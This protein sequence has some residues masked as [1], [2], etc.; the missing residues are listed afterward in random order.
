MKK[1]KRIMAVIMLFAMIMTMASGCGSEPTVQENTETENQE[2][3]KPDDEE[4]TDEPVAMGRY[5]EQVT[6]LSEQIGGYKNKIYKL[7]DGQIIISDEYQDFIVSK[8]NGATWETY[9]QD[10]FSKLLED[11]TYIHDIQVG[12]DGTVYVVVETENDSE[13]ENAEDALITEENYVSEVSNRLLIVKP[14]G[15]KQ[16]VETPVEGKWIYSVWVS[17]NGRVFITM[18]GEPIYEVKEDGSCEPFLTVD[19]IPALIQFQGNLMIIDG[20]DYDGYLIYDMEKKTYVEDEVLADFITENY[21]NRDTNGGSWHD[22][23][24]CTKEEGVLYLAGE[25]GLYRHVIGGSVMEQIVD[26]SLSTFGSPANNLEGFIPLDNNEFL[27]LFTGGKLIKYVYD[28]DIPTV[29]NEKLNIYSL[30][31]NDT[32]RQ[33]VSLYQAANPEVYVQYEVGIDE[34]SSVTKE[35]ALKSLNTRIMAGNGPDVLILDNM[36]M[37]AYVDK[38]LLMDL[39]PMLESLEEDSAVFANIVNAFEKNGKVYMMPCE[40]NLP[41]ILGREKTV[42]SMNDLKSMADGVEKMRDEISGADLIGIASER[43]IMKMFAMTCVPSWKTENGEINIQNISDFLEETKRIYDAQMNG[44]DSQIKEYW[45]N[46]NDYYMEDMGILRENSKYF[47]IG[48]DEIGFVGKSRQM[49]SGSIY[50]IFAYAMSTSVPRIK[51][52]E[53]SKL[54]L[55]PGQSQN[56]F[57]AQTIAGISAASKNTERGEEFLKV[58]LGKEN[59]VST[60][61]GLPVNKAALEEKL[62]P[63][64]KVG[65]NGEY[66]SIA[67]SDGEGNYVEMT[68][69]WPD[70]EI[71]NMLRGWIEN[72]STPY[73]EDVRLEDAVYKEG[74]LYMR[75]EK[76]LEEA[77]MAIEKSVALYMA[78]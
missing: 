74:A 66:S 31:Q 71:I 19:Q 25:K 3:N 55:M 33:A 20:Y 18:F 5:V 40:I 47:R 58:L 56:V 50:D 13:A 68:I 34:N 22:L 60:F 53:D 6:D 11:K 52:F 23:Y 70:E 63:S 15:T 8:D 76:S 36:P 64:E 29:P 30:K 35:D 2:E 17:E 46:L 14:D 37:D 73:I 4:K 65:E 10:W 44:L 62:I 49:V 27:V 26:G 39:K 54:K 1:V 9:Q 12:M 32:V 16:Y 59:Q 28:P 41:V 77:V 51:N 69:Y 72:A 78:E 75:G 21:K 7:S 57:W 42:S 61:L 38:G 24:F 67:S 45:D 43:G 48:L